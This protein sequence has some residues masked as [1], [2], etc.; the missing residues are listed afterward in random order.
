MLLRKYVPYTTYLLENL[1]NKK[2]A[3]VSPLLFNDPLDS[4]FLRDENIIKNFKDIKPK[5]IRVACLN[6][7]NKSNNIV[8]A[9]E[10]L[11]WA[12]YADSHNGIC[13]EYDV[14][15]N[16]FTP[17][18]ML[19][20]EEFN[21]ADF[22][23]LSEIKYQNNFLNELRLIV[24]E[25]ISKDIFSLFLTKDRAF[26]YENEY[27]ILKYSNNDDN[28]IFINAPIINKIIFGLRCKDSIKNVIINI[29]KYIY[30]D[31]IKLYKINDD[32]KEV[33]YEK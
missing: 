15:E 29:N 2:I 33:D 16:D 13:I 28:I 7:I 17:F 21:D 5:N 24:P 25:D 27:R 30:N 4:Y 26:E 23:I 8:V 19:G 31:N 22:L 32:F 12:H 1:I 18:P 10:M 9:N 6:Y 14:D 11:M 20:E 3:C